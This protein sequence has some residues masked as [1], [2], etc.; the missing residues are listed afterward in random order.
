MSIENALVTVTLE[1]LEQFVSDCGQVT[2]ILRESIFEGLLEGGKE[3]VDSAKSNIASALKFGTGAL[4]NSMGIMGWSN[5]EA[6]VDVTVGTN[7]PGYPYYQEFGY[8]SR[9]GRWIEGKMFL[10]YA[11]EE[12]AYRIPAIV[13]QKFAEKTAS[14]GGSA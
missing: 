6:S 8:T 1:G 13:E 3:M 14:M 11:V 4:Y 10:S 12:V 9:G 7:I 2:P 5:T